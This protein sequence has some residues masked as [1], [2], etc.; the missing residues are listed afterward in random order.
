MVK[1][2]VI[3]S[4]LT[5]D[6][7]DTTTMIK[8][9][10]YSRLLDF[11]RCPLAAKLKYVDKV[12]EAKNP[13]AER[14]TGIHLQAEQYV[15][16]EIKKLPEP[17]KHFD[18]EFDKLRNLHADG[19]VSLEGEWGFDD[20]WTPCDYKTAWLRVKG[21]AVVHMH[22]EHALVVDYKTGRKD[23]NEIKHGEQVQLYAIA[24]LIRNPDVK[25][26]TVELWYLDKDDITTVRYTRLQALRHVQSF[27]KRAEKMLTATQFPANPTIHTCKWCAFRA[28]KGGPCQYGV[29]PGQSPLKFY[30]EKFG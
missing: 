3:C 13:A 5:K 6:Y 11:E 10:S 17:L 18:E 20:D 4:N 14:G 25:K 8:N 19:K 9:W 26:V 24:T 27:H 7:N 28:D 29:V 1:S 21:D 30:R 15:R 2:N 22:D 12:P 23:G 16:G